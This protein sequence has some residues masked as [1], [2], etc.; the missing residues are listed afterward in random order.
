M[1]ANGKSHDLLYVV[2]KTML[3][4]CYN[5]KNKSFKHYGARGIYVCERWRQC[6]ENFYEDMGERP[7]AGA[8]IDRINNDGPYCKEN[9]RWATRLEQAKTRRYHRK[10]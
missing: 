7:F 8:T 6:F 5:P 1:T 10:P 9:C 3:A 4:R 2:W